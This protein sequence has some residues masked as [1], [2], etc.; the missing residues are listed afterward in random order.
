MPT[1]A[2]KSEGKSPPTLDSARTA[3]SSGEIEI[4][5]Q[6]KDTSSTTSPG[7]GDGFLEFRRPPSS[8]ATAS[9]TAADATS[10]LR[11]LVCCYCRLHIHCTVACDAHNAAALLLL[12]LL[13]PS[14]SWP[15]LLSSTRVCGRYANCFAGRQLKLF[16]SRP[17]AQPEPTRLPGSCSSEPTPTGAQ[18]AWKA[19]KYHSVHIWRPIIAP[20]ASVCPSPCDVVCVRPPSQSLS[21]RSLLARSLAVSSLASLE[22]LKT[23][24]AASLSPSVLGQPNPPPS[25][26]NHNRTLQTVFITSNNNLIII[27][28]YHRR[29]LNYHRGECPLMVKSRNTQTTSPDQLAPSTFGSA[30]HCNQHT[31]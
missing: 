30:T 18:S 6:N 19:Q 12:L 9:E 22:F 2:A 8:L 4:A 23:T 14:L 17:R 25:A 15:R 11:C 5:N 16:V 26:G 27:S 29:Q 3:D 21:A 24:F 20:F 7:D 1:T 13:L 31:L 10:H 28:N